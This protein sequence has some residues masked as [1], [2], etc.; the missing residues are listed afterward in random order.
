MVDL[1]PVVKWSGIQMVVQKPDQKYLLYGQKCLVFK[2]SVWSCDKYHLKTGFLKVRFS[3]ESGVRY[4]D[5]YCIQAT[6]YDLPDPSNGCILG[7]KGLLMANFYKNLVGSGGLYCPTFTR[8]Y[9][10][11]LYKTQF[12]NSIILV[13]HSCR[14]DPLDICQGF[15]HPA[16]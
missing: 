7:H 14:C 16:P 9:N 8:L 3:N 4:S 11:M 10:V 15:G 6:K 12:Q 13:V 2:W 5:E 1:C